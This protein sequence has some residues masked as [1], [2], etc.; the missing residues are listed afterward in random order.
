VANSITDATRSAA[1]VLPILF[2]SLSVLRAYETRERLRTIML[3]AS[4]LAIVIPTYYT[5]LNEIRWY[6]PAP[7][8]LLRMLLHPGVASLMS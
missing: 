4:G 7:L 3:V 2:V 5:G 6:L 8:Q 1:Y